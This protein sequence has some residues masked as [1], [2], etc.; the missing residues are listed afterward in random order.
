MY[1]A[2]DSASLPHH[3]NTYMPQALLQRWKPQS[4]TAASS[5]PWRKEIVE[6]VQ[7]DEVEA[8]EVMLRSMYKPELP[9]EVAGNG[10]LLLK[11]F[12]LADR[13]FLVTQYD[14]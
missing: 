12:T 11:A 10:R 4:A 9:E 3:A 5:Q 2:L 6:H 8:F 7:E 14:S 13:C 1:M